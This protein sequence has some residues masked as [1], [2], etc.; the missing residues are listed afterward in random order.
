MRRRDR[1]IMSKLC[2]FA[3]WLLIVPFGTYLALSRGDVDGCVGGTCLVGHPNSPKVLR[4]P[5]VFLAAPTSFIETGS[6]TLASS[7]KYSP[8]PYSKVEFLKTLFRQR[9]PS[10]AYVRPSKLLPL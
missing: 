1:A 5:A 2:Q 9:I 7:N 3:F 10:T 8:P 6:E 4:N